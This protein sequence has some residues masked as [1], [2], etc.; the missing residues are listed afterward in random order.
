MEGCAKIA[1][2]LG[3]Q[4]FHY[5]KKAVSS[6][7]PLAVLSFPIVFATYIVNILSFFYVDY[8]YGIGIDLDLPP[9]FSAKTKSGYLS[10]FLISLSP[11]LGF[12]ASYLTDTSTSHEPRIPSH[13]SRFDCHLSGF[14][15]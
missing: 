13:K 4:V 7:S 3:G 5:A 9:S 10:Y 6:L 14:L 8:L 11:G 15:I 2:F 12:S 1:D